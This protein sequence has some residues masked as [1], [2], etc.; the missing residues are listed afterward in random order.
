MSVG[1]HATLAILICVNTLHAKMWGMH[2]GLTMAWRDHNSR[3]VVESV[4]KIE[5]EMITFIATLGKQ[6]S[7]WWGVL[8]TF[9]VWIG[10]LKFVILDT[11]G[12]EVLTWLAI[13]IVF[14]QILMTF[15]CWVYFHNSLSSNSYDILLLSL[16]PMSLLPICLEVFE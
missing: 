3:L 6:F 2:L 10:M 5:I 11:K 1:S 7:I 12:S 16:L 13:I 9:W 4:S 14:R 15:C 8:V